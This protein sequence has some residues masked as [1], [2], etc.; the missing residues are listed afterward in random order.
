LRLLTARAILKAAINRKES[1][2]AHYIKN[3]HFLDRK[4]TII[5]IFKITYGKIY[6]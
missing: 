6:Y 2:G 3:W 4:F 5:D 1:L